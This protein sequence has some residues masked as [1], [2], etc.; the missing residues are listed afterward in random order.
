MSI[1]PTEEQADAIE[2]IKEWWHR[3]DGFLNERPQEFLLDGGAGTGKAQPLDVKV[4]TPNGYRRFGDLK[5]G[6]LVTGVNGKPFSVSGVFPQGRIGG[7]RVTFR[8]RTSTLCS[9]DHL[10]V[11]KA[12]YKQSSKFKLLTTKE[13]M[14][15]LIRPNGDY[16]WKIPL[17]LPVGRCS[18]L[19]VG[20]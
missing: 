1:Q 10:W 13:I 6:D 15:S 9:E 14:K 16:R 11:V 12:G 2:A 18:Y 4:V 3:I 7:Y 19:R 17:C 20:H 8:D 5:I